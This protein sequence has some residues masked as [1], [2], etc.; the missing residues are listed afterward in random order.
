M[1]NGKFRL[2]I[3]IEPLTKVRKMVKS[4]DQKITFGIFDDFIQF[5]IYVG[6]WESMSSTWLIRKASLRSNQENSCLEERG[7]NVVCYS[8][9]SLVRLSNQKPRRTNSTI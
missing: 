1:K 6:I 4:L 8:D 3:N 2:N 7:T 5:E 9:R